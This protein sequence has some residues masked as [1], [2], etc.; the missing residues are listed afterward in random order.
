[1]SGRKKEG[2]KVMDTD[3]STMIASRKEVWGKVEKGKGGGA[4]GNG[5]FDLD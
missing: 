2:K 1:M 4:N 3:K 5:R